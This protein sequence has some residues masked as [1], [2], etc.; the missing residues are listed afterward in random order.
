MTGKGLGVGCVV[1]WED[2]E[3]ADGGKSDKYLVIVGCNT[4]MNYLGVIGTSKK[5]HRDFKAGCNSDG[6]WYHIPAKFDWFKL[7]TWLLIAEPREI[8]PSEF[9]K[10]SMQD[11]TLEVRAHLRSEVAGAIKNCMKACQDVSADHIKLL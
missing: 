9:L 8:S 3:F 5:H 6:G 7:D 10:L 2:Y 4:G 11:K 1:H